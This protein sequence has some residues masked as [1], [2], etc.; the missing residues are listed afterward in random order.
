MTV[1]AADAA[2]ATHFVRYAHHQEP[3]SITRN[4]YYS[5]WYYST[6]R[7]TISLRMQ[8]RRRRKPASLTA[9]KAFGVILRDI[10]KERNLSQE[11]LAF[12]SGYHPT[13]IGQ[14]ERGEKSPSLRTIM[15]LAGALR[16]PGSEMLRRVEARLGGAV[17]ERPHR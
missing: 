17:P 12:E 16:T 13:Y 15:N 7:I 3:L 2:A 8:E 9:E 4:L 10:R 6:D 5:L 1:L 14:M 11:T